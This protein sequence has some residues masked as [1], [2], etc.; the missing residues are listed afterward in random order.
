MVKH[1]SQI[2]PLSGQIECQ[3]NT[4]S[5]KMASQINGRLN[6]YLRVDQVAVLEPVRKERAIPWLYLKLI[7]FK[8]VKIQNSN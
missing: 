6:R 5:H 1:D 2:K 8:L 3:I 4:E 7:K